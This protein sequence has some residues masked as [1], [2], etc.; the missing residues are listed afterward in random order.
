MY[1]LCSYCMYSMNS[2]CKAS[3]L[4]S[5]QPSSP[6]VCMCIPPVHTTCPLMHCC[7]HATHRYANLCP[8]SLHQGSDL[9]MSSLHRQLHNPVRMEDKV[10]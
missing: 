8:H 4:N 2:H 5:Q 7:M 10:Q 9:G 6:Y 1:V 3:M